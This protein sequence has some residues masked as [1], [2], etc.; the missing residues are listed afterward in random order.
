[1]RG[2]LKMTKQAR[3]IWR[4][5][6]AAIVG[7][8]CKDP[9]Q[10]NSSK[11]LLTLLAGVRVGNMATTQRYIDIRPGVLRNAVARCCVFALLFGAC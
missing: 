5:G 4:T 3:I 1:M 10:R 2:E 11:L 9:K 8:R 7:L 6:A